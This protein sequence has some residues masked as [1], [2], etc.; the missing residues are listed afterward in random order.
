MLRISRSTDY[1]LLATVYLVRHPGKV[2]N[3]REIAGFYALPLPMIAKVLKVLHEGR[4][5][6]SRRGVEGGYVFEGDPTRIT[7][8]Q[9]LEVLEGPW[10]LVACESLDTEGHGV[11]SIRLDCPSRGFMFGI[12]RAIKDAF[13]QITLVDLVRGTSPTPAIE[14]KLAAFRESRLEEIQ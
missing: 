2:V 14:E 6:V 12:N 13:E 5:I 1:G 4:I 11:C 7:L 8:G 10:D 3:A 9:M